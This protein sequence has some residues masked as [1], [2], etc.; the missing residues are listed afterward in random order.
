MYWYRLTQHLGRNSIIGTTLKDPD[1]L[2]EH[3][4]ADEKHRN[5]NGEK[6]GS[7]STG[8]DKTV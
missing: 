8:S 3:L 7:G 2:P 5:L 6:A 1:K 4:L